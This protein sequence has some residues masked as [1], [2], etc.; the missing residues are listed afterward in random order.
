[1]PPGCFDG[2]F[3][4]GDPGDPTID[5]AA[6]NEAQPVTHVGLGKAEAYRSLEPQDFIPDGRCAPRFFLLQGFAFACPARG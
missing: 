2:T 5:T 1:M 6:A 4:R 3:A